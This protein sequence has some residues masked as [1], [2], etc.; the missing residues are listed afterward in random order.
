MKIELIR[1]KNNSPEEYLNLRAEIIH[2][3]KQK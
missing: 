1:L 2:L 3:E